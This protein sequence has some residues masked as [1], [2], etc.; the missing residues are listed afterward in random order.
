MVRPRAFDEDH[1]LR[2]ALDVFWAKGYNAS[3]MTDLLE[4]THLSKS[5][6]YASFGSKQALIVETL[7][8]YGDYLM[9]GP[10]AALGKP[11]ASRA[12]IEEALR[13][14][15]AVAKTP[16][17][18][19]GCFVNNCMIE[20]APHD[21]EV[22]AGVFEVMLRLEGRL[23]EAVSRGQQEGSITRAESATSLAR[24][25]VNTLAGINLAAK[26]KPDRERL[27]SIVRVA[28]RA[29]D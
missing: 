19:R 25:I 5:S 8:C 7:R 2:L 26:S 10:L 17:G 4:A 20:V 28:L 27:D 22:M 3:S 13:T 12:E 1:V 9:S 14:S 21:P 16:S 24:F 11:D 23:V 29:L 6:L 18:E 15:V